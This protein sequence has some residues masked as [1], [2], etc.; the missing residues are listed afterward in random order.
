MPGPTARAATARARASKETAARRA[1]ARHASAPQPAP[2]PTAAAFRAA[3]GAFPTGVTLLTTGR[4]ESTAV[5]TLNS[6]TAVS[7]D[8]LLLLVSVKSDGRMLPQVTR[9]GGFAVNIL[10]AE[11]RSWATHFAR[12]DRTSGPAAV[13]RLGAVTGPGGRTVVPRAA[14]RIECDL[15]DAHPTGD[16][17][18]LV[19]RVTALSTHPPGTEPP[20]PPLVFHQGRYADLAPAPDA[21]PALPAKDAA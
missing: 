17:T 9:D 12:P 18:L 13:Q 5:I 4:G 3:M 1:A 19:G 21:A 8:P 15:Y 16:H 10:T 2:T 20:A 6:L 7:L 14:V 11:Q